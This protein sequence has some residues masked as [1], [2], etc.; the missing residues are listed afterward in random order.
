[1][2]DTEIFALGNMTN[3]SQAMFERRRRIL[4]EARRMIGRG[5]LE[6]FNIRDLCEKAG[7]ASRTLYYAFD[8]KE[9]IIA[10]AIKGYFEAF[11]SKIG[12]GESLSSFEGALAHQV[13]T[14]VRNQEIPNY[15]R[16]VAAL[17]FS[18]SLHPDIRR[19]MLEIGTRSWRPW[20]QAVGLGRQ[21]RRGVQVDRM[22]IDLSNLQFA[23][24]HEWGLGELS[25]DAFLDRTL[26]AVLLLLLGATKG[27]ALKD[28][29]E[30]YDQLQRSPGFKDSLIETAHTRIMA[31]S[32]TLAE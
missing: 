25:D 3:S 12:I 24:V 18:P 11:D 7:V 28:V 23:K 6:A 30:S 8:S 19:V 10:L 15:L 2:D 13:T 16:A 27:A 1:M 29:R 4:D 26:D 22:L 31:L 32:K 17:Y 9:N 21:L 14:T 5:G 20:L